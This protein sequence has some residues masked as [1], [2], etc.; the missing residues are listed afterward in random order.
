MKKLSKENIRQ[1]LHSDIRHYVD[2]GI[3]EGMI[4]HV[5]VRGKLA[6]IE[7]KRHKKLAKKANHY[8]VKKEEA[9]FLLSNLKYI[10]TC[11]QRVDIR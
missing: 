4:Y 6:G 5:E 10:R 2:S 11:I 3:F 7:N 8:T 1:L 9:N